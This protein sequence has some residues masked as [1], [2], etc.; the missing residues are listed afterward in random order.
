MPKFGTPDW[1][2]TFCETVNNNDA[3]AEAAATWE[4]DFIFVV[5]PSGNLDHEILMYIGLYHGDCTGAAVLKEGEEYKLLEKGE[6]PSGNEPP[7]YEAEFLYEA[8]YDDWV[9][10]LKKELDPIRALLSG[11][12]KVKGDMAKIMRA[13][14]AAQELVRSTTLMETEF[15]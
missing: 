5:N 15:Y 2:K 11:K 10:I 6:E 7:P 1:A 4:G 12:A 8:K 9:K 13:T 3:Y 14:K